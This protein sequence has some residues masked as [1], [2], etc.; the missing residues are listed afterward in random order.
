MSEELKK[1]IAELYEAHSD[2][3]YAYILGILGDA[4]E[5]ADIVSET[6]VR[7]FSEPRLDDDGFNSR[8]WLFTV[9]TNL[10]RNHIGRYLRRFLSFSG[11][12]LDLHCSKSP[13]IEEAVCKNDEFTRLSKK[14]QILERTDREIIF[15]KYFEE[16]SYE[17]IAKITGLGESAVGSRLSRA[18]GRLSNELE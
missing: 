10:S 18:I 7:A 13:T 3:I 9:A 11:S 16:M 2:R 17:E 6:F 5:A 12:D 1:K 14:L 8:A 4:S 15:L